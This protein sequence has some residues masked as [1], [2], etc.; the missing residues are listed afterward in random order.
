[1]ANIMISAAIF[2][3]QFEGVKTKNGT[4]HVADLIQNVC[5]H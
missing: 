3:L 2:F 4:W 1:M 5:Y